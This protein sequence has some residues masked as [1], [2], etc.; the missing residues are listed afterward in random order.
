[1]E[2][3]VAAE[4]DLP[5]IYPFYSTIMDEGRTYAFPDHGL[6]GLHLMHRRL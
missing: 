4:E 6:L 1:V 2:I 5:A 3:R